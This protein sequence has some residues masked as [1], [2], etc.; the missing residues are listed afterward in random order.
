MAT[1]RPGTVNDRARV[2]E[3]NQ[4]AAEEPNREVVEEVK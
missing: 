4:E 1:P 2:E 3:P